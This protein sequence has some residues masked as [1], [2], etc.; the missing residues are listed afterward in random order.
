[1]DHKSWLKTRDSMKFLLAQY[2]FNCIKPF[3]Q[4]FKS[5]CLTHRI[6]TKFVT[7]AAEFTPEF[8]QS[9]YPVS[10]PFVP[11]CCAHFVLHISLL[12]LKDIPRFH[13]SLYLYSY[14]SM[15]SLDSRISL[16]TGHWSSGIRSSSQSYFPACRQ[17]MIP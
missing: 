5:S 9:T 10:S 3:P 17:R 16:L 2:K 11:L 14:H 15:T 12:S 6:K 1:M 8:A 4:T 7:M 13:S